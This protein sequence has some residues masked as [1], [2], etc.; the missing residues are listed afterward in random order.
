MH[1][2]KSAALILRHINEA[3]LAAAR[4]F[5]DEE[6]VQMLSRWSMKDAALPEW[7]FESG[8]AAEHAERYAMLAL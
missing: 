1:A 2:G 5:H 3:A 8:L 4:V 7:P 6:T